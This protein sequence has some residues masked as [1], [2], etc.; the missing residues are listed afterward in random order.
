[1]VEGPIVHDDAVRMLARPQTHLGAQADRFMG[2][3]VAVGLFVARTRPGV[4]PQP[5][6]TNAV[7]LQQAANE[8][9]RGA[10]MLCFEGPAAG[11]V[12]VAM[13]NGDTA[14]LKPLSVAARQALVRTGIV[15]AGAWGDNVDG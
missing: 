11:A 6:A 14:S 2:C 10:F 13:S 8:G 7:A 15:R 4:A 5:G 3:D 1:M 9:Y 12:V